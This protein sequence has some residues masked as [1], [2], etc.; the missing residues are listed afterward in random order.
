MERW[1][2]TLAVVTD[3]SSD[4]GTKIVEKLLKA[5]INVK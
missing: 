3:A 1:Y 4:I 5:G 2:G